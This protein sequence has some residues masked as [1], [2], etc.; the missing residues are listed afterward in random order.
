M[1]LLH[2]NKTHLILLLLFSWSILPG[3]N[4]D[5]PEMEASFQKLTEYIDAFE[6]VPAI[7]LADSLISELKRNEQQ[8]CP[9][10]L[11]I[12]YEKGEALELLRN[13]SEVALKIYYEIIGKGEKLKNWEIVAETYLSIARIHE[14]IGRPKDCLRNLL[15]ART[16]IEKHNL[17]GVFS[18]F[19]VRYASYHRIYDNR[20]S[21]R[22]YAVK[23]IQFGK[24]YNVQRSEVDGYLLMGILTA[25]LEKSVDFFQEAVNL[26][27]EREAYYG[28]ASQ[29]TNIASRYIRSGYP[30]KAFSHLEEAKNFA[31]KIPENYNGYYN[32]FQRIY[33]LWRQAFEAQGREDSAYV[34]LQKSVASGEQADIRVNQQKVSEQEIAFAI[35]KEQAKLRFE[36][37][38]SFYLRW[39]MLLMIIL[40]VGMILAH[41]NNVKKKQYIAKQKDLISK[42]NEELN[43]SLRKQSML[44]SEVHH[45]V[46]NNLQLVM[47]L[48][49]LKGRKMQD[50]NIQVHFD[51]LANKV[52]SIALIHEQLYRAGEFDEVDLYNYLSDLTSHFQ[53]LQSED[54][55]FLLEL[56][57]NNV[58]LNLET[59][60][61][62][63]IICS[64]LISNS[65]K[66]ARQP[67]RPLGLK[68]SI[69]KINDEFE[70]HYQD[71]GP[72]YPDKTLK[73]K[74]NSMGGLL[75][76]SMVR[77]LRGTSETKNQDG[78]VFYMKFREKEVSK[79]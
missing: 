12:Q 22:V 56:E 16:V 70:F 11:W 74:P 54:S 58:Q 24:D 1:P 15:E 2:F 39:G 63:G 69:Q 48:L 66:Y 46:K 26:Y 14:I 18:R 25:D 40:L 61:P 45:R 51:D 43:I 35:E 33:D 65:L 6:P 60:L 28:A 49:T 19:A 27:L 36:Q 68:L 7:A 55:P 9:L 47:S 10:Y 62:L 37:Q 67:N 52:H 72:G 53:S 20:D 30:E 5:L 31:E 44:L 41:F 13:E 76:N 34:Y 38:R 73:H 23:A 78:A 75:I 21:A 57:T 29:K 71:N 17:Y 59:V 32:I 79:V 3:K 77:Q 4:C 42:Q 50:S 64:E 8:D